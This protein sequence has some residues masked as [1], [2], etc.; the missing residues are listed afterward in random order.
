MA[1]KLGKETRKINSPYDTPIFRGKPSNGALGEAN[2]DGSIVIDS[3][4][5][6]NS[7]KFKRAVKHEMQHA[8][9]MKTGR[10]AYGENWVMWEGDI[11]IRKLINGVPHIAGPAGR[12]PDGHPDHPWEQVAIQAED[13]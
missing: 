10:A 4:I 6:V 8:M 11:Y 5:P 1:F 2:N 9:D 13:L 7:D 12:L 3:N